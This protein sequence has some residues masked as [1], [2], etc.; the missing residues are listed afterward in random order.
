MNIHGFLVMA[1]YIISRDRAGDGSGL[2]IKSN[3]NCILLHYNNVTKFE[4]VSFTLFLCTVYDMRA[5]GGGGV[6]VC[7][8]NPLGQACALTRLI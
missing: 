8:E 6:V 5:W 4:R 2:I 3:F 7:A 1:I